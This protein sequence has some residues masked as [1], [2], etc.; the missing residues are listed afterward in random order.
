MQLD[1]TDLK[2]ISLV[3]KDAKQT[4]KQLALQLE[5]S[6]TAVYERVRKLEREGVITG[7][8]ALLDREKL[9]KSFVAFCHVRLA[10][11]TADNV[12]EF[13]RAVVRLTEVAECY[14]VSGDYDYMLK[15]FV[16][17]MPAYRQFMVEK[18]TGLPHIG[19]THSVFMIGGIKE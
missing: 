7:Y 5:L 18:L 10:R 1:N 12:K 14:H 16:A 9:G 13:E 8:T 4:T 6:N 17:D 11:H 15:I 19:N 2:L 3:Q